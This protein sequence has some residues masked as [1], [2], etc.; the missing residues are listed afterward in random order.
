MIESLLSA[1]AAA[2]GIA[3][4][5]Q[6]TASC[7]DDRLGT[8]SDFQFGEYGFDMRLNRAHC[9]TLAQ[10]NSLVAQPEHHLIE[11]RLLSVR[12]RR[13]VHRLRNPACGDRI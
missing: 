2:R 1:R 5:Y 10:R 7:D 6:S 11:Y 12:Q 9:D 4:F 8:A 3:L 13:L